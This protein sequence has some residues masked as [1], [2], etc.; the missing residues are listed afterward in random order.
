MLFEDAAATH[1]ELQ[2]M[3]LPDEPSIGYLEDACPSFHRLWR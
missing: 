2:E 1:C 3:S